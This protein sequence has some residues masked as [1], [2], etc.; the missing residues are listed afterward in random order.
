[1]TTTISK[2]GLDAKK[3]TLL[4]VDDDPLVLTALTRM[5]NRDGY[6]VLSARDAVEALQVLARGP[7]DVLISDIDMP[8]MNGVDLLAEVKARWP[9]VVRILLSGRGSL[10]AALKAINEG[11]VYRFLT[12]PITRAELTGTVKEAIERLEEIRRAAAAGRAAI[13]RTQLAEA[14]EREHPGITEVA[15]FDG[16]YV[17]DIERL[18]TTIEALPP[19]ASE[20]RALAIPPPSQS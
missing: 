12:K 1:M 7:V 2:T 15:L 4:V 18:D 16:V 20:L 10:E 5:L 19:N 3:H 14:L 11:E 13:N 9:D 17:L 8:G 6:V